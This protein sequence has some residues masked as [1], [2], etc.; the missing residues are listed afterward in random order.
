MTVS[1]EHN[2]LDYDG[3]PMN[4]D[5]LTY[6][7]INLTG[8]EESIIKSGI[9]GNSY[10]FQA[11]NN[12]QDQSFM[13]FA[14]RAR[15]RGGGS[16]GVYVPYISVGQPYTLPLK[17][18]FANYNPKMT[19]IQQTPEDGGYAMWGFNSEDP[20]GNGS[21]DNDNGIA[22]MEVMFIGGKQR[23]I[24]GKIDLRKAKKPVLALRL[25]HPKSVNRPAQNLFEVQISTT[26]TGL[27]AWETVEGHTV[28]EWAEG[29]YGWQRIEVDLSKYVGNI[30][31]MGFVATA[32]SHTF[33]CFDAFEM[34][35]AKD[36]NLGS[37]SLSYPDEV[38][39]GTEQKFNFRIKNHGHAAAE[40]YTVNLYRNGS[41]RKT[42][43]GVKL[44]PGEKHNYEF[45][46]VVHH[47]EN[48]R[49]YYYGLIEYEGDQDTYDNKSKV[50]TIRLNDSPF[51]TVSD[52]KG[53]QDTPGSIRLDWNAPVVPDKPSQITDDFE[54]YESWST[55]STGGFGRYTLYD[56]DDCGVV[57]I[58]NVTLPNVGLN[59]KQSWFIMDDTLSPLDEI[60]NAKSHSGHKYLACLALYDPENG[61]ADD[62]IVSP[63]LTGEAQTISFWARSFSPSYLERFEILATSLNDK[64]LDAL[65]R[66]ENSIDIV[67]N[68]PAEWTK[69]S[70][71]LPAGTKYFAI[72]HRAYGDF[73]LFVDD[74]TYTPVGNERLT[75][76]GYNIYRNGKIVNEQPI[77]PT[78]FNHQPPASGDHTYGISALYN[79]GESPLQEVAISYTGVNGITN[80]NIRIESHHGRI[81]IYGAA[82]LEI[83]IASADGKTLY[84]GKADS[85]VLSVN[86]VPGVYAV[87]IAGKPVKIIVK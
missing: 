7:V 71:N 8:D 22:L 44:Q 18:S 36:K 84:A 12:D 59:S 30:V 55:M 1:W 65:C 33:T 20:N 64:S 53:V 42:L 47:G 67:Y 73:M 25:L 82:E 38:Y 78:T 21:Y 39:P 10:T 5:H 34:D 24:T 60:E 31:Y 57:G 9:V 72:R 35:E 43:E 27:D 62:W 68:V 63:E 2:P 66:E 13:R 50:V 83:Q 26:T 52:V 4:P 41:L 28:Q 40:N 86:A 77:T 46:D 49:N 37:I 48:T 23:L 45:V 80:D 56:M 74:L 16:M 32:Y 75:L 85:N 6:E 29:E 61:S 87:S 11:R 19:M 14:V 79:L 76:T 17:E 70:F 58:K 15:T 54:N 51:P 81:V 69:Y 3:F